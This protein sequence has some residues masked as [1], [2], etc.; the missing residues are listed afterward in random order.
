MFFGYTD[1]FYE[2]YFFDKYNR[3]S[4]DRFDSKYPNFHINSV[5]YVMHNLN[6]VYVLNESITKESLFI[7]SL[8][9]SIFSY[10]Y[11]F[12]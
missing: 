5:I 8:L 12:F 4:L 10:T 11:S 3:L 1:S 9:L 2:K 7:G 6:I